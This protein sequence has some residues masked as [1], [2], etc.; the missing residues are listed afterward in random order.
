MTTSQDKPAQR[1]FVHK[2]IDWKRVERCLERYPSIGRVFPLNTLKQ[3]CESP[4]YYCHYMSWRLGAWPDESLLQRI[5]ELLC[6][7]EALPHW[8]NE[9]SLL[10]SAEFGDFWSLVWQLQVAEHLCEVGTDVSWAKSGPDLSVK[11]SGERWF[12]ECYTY[13]KSFDLLLFLNELLGK[14][15]QAVCTSY[16]VCSPFRLPQNS[17][18]TAFLHQVLSPFLDPAFVENAKEKAKRKYPEVLHKHPSSSL[19][20]YVDGDDV[21]TYEP[22]IVPNNV[23]NPAR[24]LQVALGEAVSA[25]RCSNDLKNHHPNIV[26]VNYLLST[27][28][29]VAKSLPERVHSLTLPEIEPNID[30]LAA[31]AIGIDERMAREKLEVIRAIRSQVNCNHLS[32]IADLSSSGTQSW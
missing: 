13:H 23:G 2:E 3:H 21:D 8:E 18:R 15:D 20:V 10:R 16:D 32:Q 14:L 27:D 19:Y 6:C 26:A 28:Y 1:H 4:P 25:K 7:A 29:Q 30:V 5:E 22:G 12:V 9:R 17:D 31:S 24:Y 11:I